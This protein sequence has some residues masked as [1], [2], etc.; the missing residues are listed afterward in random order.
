MLKYIVAL[1]LILSSFIFLFKAGGLV[2]SGG[3]LDT[4]LQNVCPQTMNR[5]G[6]GTK[7]EEPDDCLRLVNRVHAIQSANSS[8]FPYF[9]ISGCIFFLLGSLFMFQIIREDK[10]KKEDLTG[11]TNLVKNSHG[12]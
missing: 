9:V 2:V 7:T 3:H 6:S 12:K 4:H 8:V 11:V 5:D 10:T 1:F